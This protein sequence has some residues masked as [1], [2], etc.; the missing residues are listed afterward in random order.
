MLAISNN[1]CAVLPF[2]CSLLDLIWLLLSNDDFGASS[3]RSIH[4][5]LALRLTSPDYQLVPLLTPLQAL[6]TSLEPGGYAFTPNTWRV[7]FEDLDFY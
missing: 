3:V 5:V 6:M 4:S 7:G 1:L 2:G